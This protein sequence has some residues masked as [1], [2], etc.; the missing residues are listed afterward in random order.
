MA[1]RTPRDDE[2]I[3]SSTHLRYLQVGKQEKETI[4]ELVDSTRNMLRKNVTNEARK[5]DLSNVSEKYQTEVKNLQHAQ[6]VFEED[7]QRFIT[8]KADMESATQV[9]TEQ[10]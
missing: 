3:P 5:R 7:Y 6:E 1:S 2:L 4:K 8:M 9:G 10:F